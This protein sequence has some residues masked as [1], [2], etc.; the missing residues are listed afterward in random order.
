V[1]FVGIVQV[2]GFM[3]QTR[4]DT[5]EEPPDMTNAVKGGAEPS[6]AEL[7][8]LL[9]SSRHAGDPVQRGRQSAER[10]AQRIAGAAGL[11]ALAV[12]S[13]DVWLVLGPKG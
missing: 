5:H 7:Q 8:L 6:G 3:N 4:Q 13:L 12:W 2:S 9:L 11:V 1:I 10:L